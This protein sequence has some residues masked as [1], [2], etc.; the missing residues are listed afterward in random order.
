MITLTFAGDEAG[1]IS[2]AFD[3]GASRYFVVAMI[4]TSSPDTL[5]QVLTNVRQD[6]GL[7]SRYEFRF[8]HLSSAKLRQR[9]LGALAEADFESWAIIADKTALPDSFKVM[10]RLDFYL[11]FLTELIQLIPSTKRDDAILILDEF[12]SAELLRRE[13]RRF[14]TVRAIPRHFRKVEVRRSRSE[15]LIQVA[16]LVAGAILRR[17]TKDDAD[18]FDYLEPKIKKILEFRG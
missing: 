13:L 3:K 5:R 12:G 15:P 1:D 2:F 9:V 17:D 18:A 14:M 7:D 11:Y 16:D 6:S 8:H 10:H 4:A